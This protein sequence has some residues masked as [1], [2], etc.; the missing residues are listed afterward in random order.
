MKREEHHFGALFSFLRIYL[1]NKNK[2]RYLSH[3]NEHTNYQYHFYYHHCNSK[4]T[5]RKYIYNFKI[6]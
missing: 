3:Q 6:L 2:I 5:I 1:F 4:A